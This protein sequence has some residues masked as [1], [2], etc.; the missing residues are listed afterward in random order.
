[1]A[2]IVSPFECALH[3]ESPYTFLHVGIVCLWHKKSSHKYI[4]TKDYRSSSQRFEHYWLVFILNILFFF[5]HFTFANIYSYRVWHKTTTKKNNR[6]LNWIF[7]Q[8]F[9]WEYTYLYWKR[10]QTKCD[11]LQ[12]EDKRQNT[13]LEFRK[14]KIALPHT[15]V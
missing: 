1:M 14:C 4:D 10:C 7:S 8:H 2:R 9:N 3:C 5:W 11:W 6:T 12:T 15:R 13:L